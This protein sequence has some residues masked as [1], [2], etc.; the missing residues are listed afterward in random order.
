[1]SRPPNRKKC[2]GE[3]RSVSAVCVGGLCLR[4]LRDLRDP[5]L[6][7]R[8]ANCRGD[9]LG[10]PPNRKKIVGATDGLCLRAPVSRPPKRKNVGASGGQCRRSVSAVCVYATYATL[11]PPAETK[12]NTPKP[13]LY[14]YC[15]DTLQGFSGTFRDFQGCFRELRGRLAGPRGH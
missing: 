14:L 8:N 11:R 13:P 12:R 1:M 9:L 15:I 5:S 3:R 10:R 4:D 6:A 7:R 2:R